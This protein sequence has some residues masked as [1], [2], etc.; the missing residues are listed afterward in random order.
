[1]R[2]S[3]QRTL[4]IVTAVILYVC[5]PF[6]TLG[7]ISPESR[8][9]EVSLTAEDYILEAARSYSDADIERAESLFRQAVSKYPDMDAAWYYLGLIN[10]TKGDNKTAEEFFS[11]AASLDSTNFWYLASLAGLYLNSNDEAKIITTCQTIHDRFPRKT[12]PQIHMILGDYRKSSGQDSLALIHYEDALRI[13]SS[14]TPA[15]FSIAEIYRGQGNYF[16]YFRHMEPFLKDGNINSSFKSEYLN[17]VVL[18][19]QFVGAFKPQVDSMILSIRQAHPRDSAAIGTAA[20]YYMRSDRRDEALELYRKNS[21]LYPDAHDICIEYISALY[22]LQ[23]WGELEAGVRE[24]MEKFPDDETLSEVLAVA[25]WHLKDID[26]AIQTYRKQLKKTDNPSI[27]LS[28]CTALGDLYQETDELK[29]AEFYYRKGLTIDPEYIPLLNNYA[30][31]LAK[32]GKNYETG[33][34]MSKKTILNEPDNPTYLDTYGWLLYLTGDYQEAKAQFKRAM[35]FGGKENGVIMDH[36]ADVLWA[37]K[38]YE[39][40]LIYYEQ[41]EKLDASL[42][43][44]EKIKA[45]KKEIDK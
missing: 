31:F 23:K 34:K 15:H 13:N 16:L 22:Y 32:I 19:P 42:N 2:L 26:G 10:Q 21:R 8:L 9:T 17:K 3:Y 44:A 1:M 7:Q 27:R 25:L 41:A 5:L 20:S 30:Y 24:M 37:L 28:C 36:Y 29:K 6:Q 14:Y 39:M 38:D 43:I 33:L 45:K 4:S 40:A 12:T 35:L 18:T 11:K